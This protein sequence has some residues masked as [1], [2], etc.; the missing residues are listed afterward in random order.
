MPIVPIRNKK[1]TQYEPGFC[2]SSHICTIIVFYV[3]TVLHENKCIL[4]DVILGL[5]LVAHINFTM[6]LKKICAV[7]L[8]SI[9][10]IFYT[11]WMSTRIIEPKHFLRFVIQ[12]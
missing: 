4:R 8:F 5:L 6:P 10:F 3:H 11:M 1:Y 12:I 7:S 9:L 2:P